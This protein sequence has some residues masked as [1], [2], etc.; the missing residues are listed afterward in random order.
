MEYWLH[1][2]AKKSLAIY[3]SEKCVNVS[4][5]VLTCILFIL[6]LSVTVNSS[7]AINHDVL[8]VQNGIIFCV[9]V[10]MCCCPKSTE[11]RIVLYHVFGW[12]Q[13]IS[14]VF[15]R[16]QKCSSF[17]YRCLLG[18]FPVGCSLSCTKLDGLDRNYQCEFRIAEKPI[19]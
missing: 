13:N 19:H 3:F 1:V 9:F 15:M 14:S 18:I 17:S 12:C 5:F 6:E 4:D 2:L 16:V 11:P 10:F 7:D 8:A